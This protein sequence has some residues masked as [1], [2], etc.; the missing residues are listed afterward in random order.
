MF[1][2]VDRVDDN[3]MFRLYTHGR[4]QGLISSVLYVESLAVYFW[5]RCFC[6]T[7]S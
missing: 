1:I 2:A 3:Q 4:E 5:H 6:T 7:T